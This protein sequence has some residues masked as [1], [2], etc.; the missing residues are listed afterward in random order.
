[1][2]SDKPR[3]LVFAGPN[4]SGKSTVTRAGQIVGVYVN[5][6][7]LKR[8]SGCTD[9]EAA[10]RAEAVRKHLL[11]KR[12]DFTFET[13]LSTERNLLLLEEAKNAGYT[14]RAVFVLT[15][16]ASINI[17][18][19]RGRAAAGGHDI[20]PEKIKSRYDKALKN[21][22]RLSRI[23]DRTTVVDNT[24]EAPDVICEIADGSAS[25]IPNQYWSKEDILRLL[26]VR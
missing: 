20:P 4:G 1:M 9:L 22:A 3:I 13:V 14:I 11:N 18:R 26:T 12:M 21:L 23:A 2:S 15:R 8:V 25:V 16:D 19:V 7:D 17:E 10:Q 6:D 5:A 24:G